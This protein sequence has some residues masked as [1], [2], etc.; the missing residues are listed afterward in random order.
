M[1]SGKSRNTSKWQSFDLLLS[2]C[3]LLGDIHKES[4][5]FGTVN[6]TEEMGPKQNI[7]VWGGGV[8]SL[9]R[10]EFR[11]FSESRFCILTSAF[12]D[13]CNVR[14]I[15][16]I[17]RRPKCAKRVDCG[18]IAGNKIAC[19]NHSFHAFALSSQFFFYPFPGNRN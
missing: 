16:S 18:N 10:Y 7:S 13:R 9:P 12:E 14:A 15:L 2:Q 8:I 4:N 3:V 19:L 5:I 1:G 6:Y 11:P 17:H